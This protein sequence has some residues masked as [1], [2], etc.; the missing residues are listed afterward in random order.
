MS[1]EDIESRIRNILIDLFQVG[2]E[3]ITATTSFRD[4]LGANSLNMM[5]LI[6][7]L[8]RE[9]EGKISEGE[10]QNITTVG[11]A[12]AYIHANIGG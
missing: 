4:D 12:V 5:E 10:A 6:M 8:E 1:V 9:F 11:Q 2:E 7:N 3:D